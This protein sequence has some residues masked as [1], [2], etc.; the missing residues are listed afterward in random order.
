MESNMRKLIIPILI[1]IIVVLSCL[2]YLVSNKPPIVKEV[3]K[4]VIK[5]VPLAGGTVAAGSDC[6]IYASKIIDL[7]TGTTVA[8]PDDLI[9]FTYQGK[10][11]LSTDIIK[12]IAIE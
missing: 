5:E 11:I 7:R 3:T 8:L 12:P 4:E 1:L 6:K 9:R 2:L 10:E